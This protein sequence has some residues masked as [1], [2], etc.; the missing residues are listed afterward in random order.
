MAIRRALVRVLGRTR[1]L[2]AGDVL[3]GVYPPYLPVY[4]VNGAV[5]TVYRR[6]GIA[7][8]FAANVPAY[9]ADGSELRVATDSTFAVPVTKT[10]GTIIQATAGTQGLTRRVAYQFANLAGFPAAG[11]P[12]RLYIAADTRFEYLW[13]GNGYVLASSLETASSSLTTDDVAEGSVNLYFT[14]VRVLATV[15]DGLVTTTSSAITAADTL[16]IA[17]GKL[18]AQLNNKLNVNGNGSQLTALNATQLTSGTVPSARLSGSYGI[19]ITGAAATATTASTATA[20][21]T[22]RTINTVSFDGTAN[23]AIANIITGVEAGYGTN[24]SSGAGWGANIWGMGPAYDGSGLA[25]AF[26]TVGQYGMSWLRA[27]HTEADAQVGE[28]TYIYQNGVMVGGVGSAGIKTAGVFYGN[29]SGVTTLNASNLSSGTVPSG[30]LTGS[31]A[32]SVTGNAATATVLQT[33]RTIN[34]VSFNG[35]A[36]ITIPSGGVFSAS[37]VSPNQTIAVSGRINLSHGLGAVPTVFFARLVCIN[38]ASGYA[39]G[40][41]ID[42]G[43]IINTQPASDTWGYQV[44]VTSTTISVQFPNNPLATMFPALIISGRTQGGTTWL[45]ATEWAI[46]FYAFV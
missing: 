42:I 34:G 39:V 37:Y 29:G 41:E 16:L 21:A 46:K 43:P 22:P 2:P 13:S 18:Q 45:D 5:I 8:G 23:I 35:S 14:A 6:D 11:S 24:N 26:T 3:N 44:W 40:T 19:D 28:G 9:K 7:E 4:K 12:E 38:A 33:A 30:R 10:L 27:A 25:T 15:L 31:Y 36:N 17:M 32:I 20:L 1:Q